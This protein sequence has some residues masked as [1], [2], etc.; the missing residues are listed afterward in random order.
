MCKTKSKQILHWPRAQTV[1]CFPFLR[2]W[3]LSSL[4][5]SDHRMEGKL[6]FLSP[7]PEKNLLTGHFI[8]G[9]LQFPNDEI[10]LPPE[11][12]KKRTSQYL[13]VQ[14]YNKTIILVMKHYSK[15]INNH[16]HYNCIISSLFSLTYASLQRYY[17]DLQINL[18]LL[19][20]VFNF[21]NPN[22]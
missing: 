6:P 5:N 8:G 16:N 18:W 4:L 2:L 12:K 3:Q 1:S 20:R 15:Y 17:L 11:W 14:M 10:F 7:E 22:L 19:R 21:L 9:S 13:K